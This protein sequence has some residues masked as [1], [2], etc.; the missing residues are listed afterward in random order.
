MSTIL[1]LDNIT[2]LYPGVTALDDVSLSFEQG[3]VHAIMGENGAGKSTLIKTIGGAIQPNSGTITIG[4]NSFDD[5][6]SFFGKRDRCH[7]SGIQPCS[8][9][10]CL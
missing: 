2:K 10:I 7:L 1:K 6:K 9:S 8:V 3:E 5:T 4:E